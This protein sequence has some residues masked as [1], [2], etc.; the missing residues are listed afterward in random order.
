[1]S[2]GHESTLNREVS[3]RED[4]PRRNNWC[5]TYGSPRGQVMFEGVKGRLGVGG[6]DLKRH[7]GVLFSGEDLYPLLIATIGQFIISY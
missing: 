5:L 1:M 7:L 2:L 3:Y 6:V 4:D